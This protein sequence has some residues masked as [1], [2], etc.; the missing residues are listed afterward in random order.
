MYVL[1]T[2][3]GGWIGVNANL[4]NFLKQVWMNDATISQN[5]TRAGYP[6]KGSEL[7]PRDSSR[8]EL[9]V[10]ITILLYENWSTI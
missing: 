4:K 2:P 3:R 7:L 10:R 9:E 8:Y 5:K 6:V 1:K